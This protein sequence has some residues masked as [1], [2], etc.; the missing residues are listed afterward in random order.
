[1]GVCS[2]LPAQRSPLLLP[3]YEGGGGGCHWYLEVKD[4]DMSGYSENRSR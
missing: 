3:L 2:G 1:M 4:E